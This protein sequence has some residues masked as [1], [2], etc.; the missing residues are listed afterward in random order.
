[1]AHYDVFLSC[2]PQDAGWGTKIRD[3][4]RA[5]GYQVVPADGPYPPIV[6]SEGPPPAPESADVLIV[7]VS[8]SYFR[9]SSIPRLLRTFLESRRPVLPVIVRET[10]LPSELRNIPALDLTAVYPEEIDDAVAAVVRTYTRTRQHALMERLPDVLRANEDPS[11][12]SAAH[13]RKIFVIHAHDSDDAREIWSAFVLRRETRL[14]PILWQIDALLDNPVGHGQT[15][16]GNGID[17]QVLPAENGDVVLLLIS[18]GLL[19]SQFLESVAVEKLLA[20]QSAGRLIVIPVITHP[21]TWQRTQLRDLTPLPSGGVPISEW[22]SRDAAIASVVEGVW[23]AIDEATRNTWEARSGPPGGAYPAG[24]YTTPPAPLILEDNTPYGTDPAASTEVFDLN[25]VFKRSGVPSLTF[26][27]PPEFFRLIMA[28]RTT[29]RGIVVEGPSGIGKTTLLKKALE[30]AGPSLGQVQVLSARKPA[31][32]PAIERL[33]EHH[34]GTVAVDDFHRLPA[35]LRERLLDHLKVLADE[36]SAAKLLVVGIPGTGASLV[37]LGFDVATRIDVFRLSAAGLRTDGNALVLDVIGKGEQALNL[38][39]KDR[40]Q[41]VRA[42]AGSLLTAQML[43]WELAVLHGVERTQPFSVEIAGDVTRAETRVMR[44]L[45]AKYD[46]ELAGFAALDGPAEATCIHLLTQLGRHDDGVLRLDDLREDVRVDNPGFAAGIDAFIRSHPAGLTGPSAAIEKHLHYDPRARMIIGEDPQLLFYLRRRSAEQLAEV[47][48]KR[49]PRPRDQVFVSYSHRDGAWLE[50]LD[51]HLRP[52]IRDG[53]LDLWDDRRIQAGDR[54]LTEI[55][56]AL[57][58]AK[59]AILLV[60]ANFLASDFINHKEVPKLLAAADAGG[61]R[62]IPV[63][64]GACL[65]SEDK[66]LNMFQAA[67]PPDKPLDA[68]P[69][70]AADRYLVE[71]ARHFLHP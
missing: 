16:S 45:A 42:A 48:G 12:A 6:P 70:H 46:P 51:T 41:I 64:I 62:I 52:L 35:E 69:K 2:A 39:F 26:V 49:L 27:E 29:G 57:E 53:M 3:A 32:R 60:S 30:R 4:L 58:R 1:M 31:D 34:V 22:E 68:L 20:E 13:G 11:A 67:N 15:S 7:V 66:R 9:S 24:R 59:I 5:K 71:V 36:E 55:T 37:D 47:A 23:L 50:R 63:I 10:G 65:F 56:Q 40:A 38:V 33:P 21:I 19:R 25:D 17:N 44:D 14:E 18:R 61:C 28:L 43:C 54:W 8:P